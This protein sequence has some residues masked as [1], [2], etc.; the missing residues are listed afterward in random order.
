MGIKYLNKFL[1]NNCSKKA[2]KK[3]PF[4][5][6]SNKTIV[7]D[8][9]IY[10]YQFSGENAL[11]ENMLKTITFF[12]TY[13][14]QPIFIFDGKPPPEKMKLL[15]ERRM[16]R[17]RAVEEYEKMKA[18]MDPTL[19]EQM[20]HYRKES[21]F[22]TE[23]DIM[24]TKILLDS[25]K[26][27]YYEAEGEAD[28]LCVSFVN[29]EKAWAC[30]SDDM[31]MLVYGC[32]R[33]LSNMDLFNQ[34]FNLYDMKTILKE[35]DMDIQT[36]RQIMV[37]SG[38]DYNYDNNINLYTTIKFYNKYKYFINKNRKESF[39]SWLL[40]Y[41]QYITD[42]HLLKKTYAIFDKLDNPL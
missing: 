30:L 12:Q 2:I 25:H 16:K 9:S 23:N 20:I 15:Y 36:F 32:K 31:D 5:N 17:K 8:T 1:Q 28:E 26:I 19:E 14:I 10:L 3:I 22:I 24:Q 4:S 35:L 18:L 34:T 39:Y 38:T 41:T 13:H 37:L 6:C 7:I 11:L 40:K 42:V 27:P 21:V 29:Q 33:V